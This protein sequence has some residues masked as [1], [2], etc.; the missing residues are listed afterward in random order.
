[1][2]VV[3]A[4]VLGVLLQDPGR[5]IV[6]RRDEVRG[7]ARAT[8]RGLYAHS[9]AHCHGE[10]ARGHGRLWTTDLTPA[11]PDLTAG[12]PEPGHLVAHL[13]RTVPTPGLASPCP[14]WGR[15]LSSLEVHRLARFVAA[16]GGRSLAEEEGPAPDQGGQAP[17]RGGTVSWVV[18]TALLTEFL[19]LA[20]A[21]L[22]GRTPRR[23]EER[24]TAGSGAQPG[25]RA[26]V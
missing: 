11:P 2:T 5:D 8:P 14:A 17:G 20:S 22:K 9:C 4:L 23:A 3:L 25:P 26:G 16:L 21:V 18:L 6:N 12:A 1:M 15:T 7:A 24:G 10:D 13:S 19:L